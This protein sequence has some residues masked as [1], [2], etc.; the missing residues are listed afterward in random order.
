MQLSKDIFLKL[1][2]T[3]SFFASF[4]TGE[5]LALLKLANSESFEDGEIIFKEK[6]HGDKMYIILTGTVRI[7][8]Y[9]GNKKEEEIAI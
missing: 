4:S 6:T 5:L 9:L 1:K 7:S 8:K 2:E 3:V